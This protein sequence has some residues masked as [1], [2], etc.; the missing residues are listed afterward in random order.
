MCR[1]LSGMQSV[2]S[3]P[4]KNITGRIMFPISTEGTASQEISQLQR[5]KRRLDG[6][7][8]LLPPGAVRCREYVFKAGYE[9]S[10][11]ADWKNGEIPFRVHWKAREPKIYIINSAAISSTV[12]LGLAL[13]LVC[14]LTHPSC[15][16]LLCGWPTISTFLCSFYGFKTS[17]VWSMFIFPKKICGL[18]GTTCWWE[19]AVKAEKRNEAICL[20]P[21]LVP[22]STRNHV[23]NMTQHFLKGSYLALGG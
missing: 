9:T 5:R 18:K 17:Q 22:H 4:W 23:R 10:I 3:D 21:S 14:L 16:M 1:H 11:R 2:I 7:K 8:T 20:F 13:T 19:L 15:L 6:R 12:A